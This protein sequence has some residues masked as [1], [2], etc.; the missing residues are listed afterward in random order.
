MFIKTTGQWKQFGISTNFLRVENGGIW[1]FF[2]FRDGEIFMN[3]ECVTECLQQSHIQPYIFI[4][5]GS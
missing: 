3:I 4:L 5:F 1:V 2:F